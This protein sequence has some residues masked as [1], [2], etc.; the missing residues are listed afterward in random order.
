MSIPS[1]NSCA[2][3]KTHNS[4]LLSKDLKLRIFIDQMICFP[5]V[6]TKCSKLTNIPD[7]VDP[8]SS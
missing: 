8:L 6:F 1:D 7:I 3:N 2:Q 5:N 4:K